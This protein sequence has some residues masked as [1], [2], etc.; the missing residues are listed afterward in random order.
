MNIHMHVENTTQPLILPMDFRKGSF[1]WSS[2]QG[3]PGDEPFH[4]PV[5]GIFQPSDLKSSSF[6]GELRLLSKRG[7]QC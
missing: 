6:L 2:L 1:R 5:D 4:V 3:H 7:L